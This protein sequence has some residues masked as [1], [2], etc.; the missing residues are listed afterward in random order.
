MTSANRWRLSL[1]HLT[2]ISC[3]RTICKI[4]RRRG[5]IL[6]QKC[7]KLFNWNVTVELMISQN[8]CSTDN[9]SCTSTARNNRK[10]VIIISITQDAYWSAEYGDEQ[11]ANINLPVT[12][13]VRNHHSQKTGWCSMSVHNLYRINVRTIW[14]SSLHS[15]TWKTRQTFQAISS[16]TKSCI[17]RSADRRPH[18]SATRQE[19]TYSR[20]PAT[21]LKSN[22][23]I[24]CFFKLNK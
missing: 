23:G 12:K 10:Y 8:K 21:R 11:Q 6:F 2:R 13:N 22:A 9:S 3:C 17:W 18:R 5:I 16:K 20:I 1:D 19:N 15:F 7:D 14:I 4:C 24:K